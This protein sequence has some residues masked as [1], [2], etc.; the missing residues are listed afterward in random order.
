MV[1]LESQIDTLRMDEARERQT[2]RRNNN[3]GDGYLR[4]DGLWDIEGELRDTKHRIAAETWLTFR[5]G[6]T[7]RRW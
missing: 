4:D 5:L 2:R 3:R 7:K 1:W 6:I